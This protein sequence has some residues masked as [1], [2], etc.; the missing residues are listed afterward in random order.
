MSSAAT[1]LQRLDAV[2]QRALR[3]EEQTGVTWLEHRRNVSV[4]VVQHKT[5]VLEVSHLNS[6]R[7]PSLAVRRETKTTT[8]SDMLV[9]V[10]GSHS[11]QHQPEQ[12]D[13]GTRSR[14]P[15]VTHRQC[16]YNK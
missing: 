6:L 12:Q 10:P 4:L 1:H 8:S 7:L 9:Q 14:Q 16:Q 3:L 15:Q 5:R 2:Q 13:C 11:W